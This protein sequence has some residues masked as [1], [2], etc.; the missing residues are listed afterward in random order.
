[1]EGEAGIQQDFIGGHM[2]AVYLR[3]AQL[4]DAINGTPAWMHVNVNHRRRCFLAAIDGKSEF[5]FHTQLKK[6]ENKNNISESQ[7]RTMFAECMGLNVAFEIISRSSWTAGFTLVAEQLSKNRVF[8]AGDA[9][10]L[11]TPTGGLGYNTAIEDAANLGWK[12]AAVV[13]GWGGTDLLDS[14][15][16]ERFPSAVRNPT[17]PENDIHVRY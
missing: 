3:G 5:V 15:H 10:H 14:Y 8:L 4:Y 7:T 17:S 6:G 16:R 13:N 1:M 12:L 2:H 9:A 11:F